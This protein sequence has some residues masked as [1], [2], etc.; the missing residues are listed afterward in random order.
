LH[1][2][3][4]VVAGA[5][6]LDFRDV[7][8][9]DSNTAY[10]MASGDGASS[11]VYKTTDAGVHW[12]LLLTNPDV[13]G[14]FDSLAFWDAAHAILVGDP[15]AGHF[16]VFTT[17]DAGKTWQRQQTPAALADEGAFAA[18]GTSVVTNGKKDAWIA[19]GG[20]GGARVLHTHDGGRTWQVATTPLGGTKTTGI[21]SLAF[22]GKKHGIA[23]GGDYKNPKGTEHTVAF[24][25]DGGKTW[26]AP[27]G[28]TALSY[29]SGVAFVGGQE[30]IAVGTEGAD[31]SHDGGATWEH[32]SDLSLNAVAG[33][34]DAVWAVG[35]K[36]VI[37]KLVE[38]R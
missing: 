28:K 37:V 9:F 3:S 27:R 15:V 17:P 25:Q 23:V 11:R 8:A 24:T 35:A 13:K 38:R 19:T 5:E 12:E 26:Q 29:H 10:L 32:F 7:E 16:V 30:V 33:K 18:S 31:V 14:F 2:R 1:W 21:F 20:P 36:G 4:G 34:G 22:A 6:K